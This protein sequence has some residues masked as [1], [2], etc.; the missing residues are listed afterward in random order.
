VL[1]INKVSEVT[2][3]RHKNH[4][5]RLIFRREWGNVT[6]TCEKWKYECRIYSLWK[7]LSDNLGVKTES[8][9]WLVCRKKSV[10]ETWSWHISGWSHINF[11][12]LKTYSALLPRSPHFWKEFMGANYCRNYDVYITHFFTISCALNAYVSRNI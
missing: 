5:T 4:L 1:Q 10:A 6:C 3:H 2:N 12:K 7:I 8:L 9:T 11:I